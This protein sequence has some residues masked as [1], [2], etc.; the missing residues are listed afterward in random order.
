[1]ELPAIL[2]GN[3]TFDRINRRCSASPEVGW[4]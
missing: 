1:M 3:R 4:K 2:S